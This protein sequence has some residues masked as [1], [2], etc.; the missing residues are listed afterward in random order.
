M[1][2]HTGNDQHYQLNIATGMNRGVRRKAPHTASV[3]GGRPFVIGVSGC[4]RCG[5]GTLAKGLRDAL[6]GDVA[7]GVVSILNTGARADS[8]LVQVLGQDDYYDMRL[9]SKAPSGWEDS[10]A[11]RHAD[12]RQDLSDVRKARVAQYIVVEGFRAFHDPELTAQ[13]DLMIW[14]NLDKAECYTRRQ[15]T[16]RVPKTVFEEHLW[17]RHEEYQHDVQERLSSSLHVLDGRQSPE[18]VLEAVLH[19][20]PH[21]PAREPRPL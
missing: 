19:M 1:I 3:V 13:M 4:T 9:V 21:H 15:R 14:L 17:P 6:K 2:D 16:K 12:L 10:S 7:V 18:V 5:K 11:L 20:I 8:S